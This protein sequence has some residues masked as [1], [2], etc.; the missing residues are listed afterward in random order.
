MD[1]ERLRLTLDNETWSRYRCD[2]CQR[3][4]TASSAAARQGTV[5][6]PACP[7]EDVVPWPS[8]HDRVLR[9]LMAYEA[10]VNPVVYRAQR[11]TAAGGRD[12]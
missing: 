11:G 7:S 10:V 4:L 3:S 5:R 8:W 12:L 6:C 1:M 2:V 9:W